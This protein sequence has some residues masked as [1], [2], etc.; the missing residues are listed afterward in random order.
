MITT[1]QK[2]HL[3]GRNGEGWAWVSTQPY[4]KRVNRMNIPIPQSEAEYLGLIDIINFAP[5]GHRVVINSDSRSLCRDFYR[6]RVNG[7][8]ELAAL[9][10]KVR[11]IVRERKLDVDLIHVNTSNH[12]ARNLLR[13]K[14]WPGYE[15]DEISNEDLERK[16]VRLA[17]YDRTMR[18]IRMD[19]TNESE[20]EED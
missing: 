16:R 18:S 9:R 14:N 6:Q 7:A 17:N 12:F 15:T 5:R 1:K 4:E 13:P 3:I 11:S 10:T 8:P 20:F 2:F 19:T